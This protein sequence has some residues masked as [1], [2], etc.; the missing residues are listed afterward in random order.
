VV[1]ILGISA[2]YHDSAA[3]IVIDGKIIA[4]A[5]EERFTRLK[6]DA[7]F[8]KNAIEYCLNQANIKCTSLDAVVFYEKPFVKFER[9][10]ES[11][12]AYA[13]KSLAFFIDAIPSWLNTKLF[14]PREID[15]FF[16]NQLKCPIYFTSHHE[17]HQASAFYPSPFN[18]SAILCLDGVG[19]WDTTTWGIGNKNEIILKQKIEFPHSIGLLYS[20]F[21]G[22]LGFKVNSGEYKVMGLAPYGQPIYKNLIL[23]NLIDLKNDGSFWLNQDFFGYCKSNRMYNDNFIKLFDKKPRLPEAPLEQK[24]MDIAASIQA[25]TDDIVLKLAK[26]IKTKSMM[27]NICL[28]GGCALNCV[29]NGKLVKAKLFDNIFIQPASGDAGGALGA[30]LRIYY[31]IFNNNRSI[32]YPDSQYGSLLGPNYSNNEI[33]NILKKYNAKYEYFD[34][35]DNVAKI[36]AKYLSE[37]KIIGHFA[38]RMEFGP[39]ALGNRSIL[40]DARNSKMQKKLNIAIKK[41]ESFRPFAPS[42]LEEDAH[43][44][45]DINKTSPYMLL[46]TQITEN[47]KILIENN[48]QGLEKLQQI[49]SDIPAVTHVDYSA[50]LQ[51]VSKNT[52]AR[53]YKIINEFKNLTGYSVIV[54]TSFNVRG[55]P[56]VC[57]PEDAFKCFM[58]TDIDV[59]IIENFVLLK[60][61]QPKLSNYEE[62]EK[63]HIKD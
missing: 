62:W 17:S 37:G 1:N 36:T 42:C 24:D 56:I 8:P 63:T 52:N 3:A 12:L 2:Y 53:Y 16:N 39:R 61:N 44:Y 50:R 13:P 38:G 4:A 45:F 6:H 23:D 41:R 20:T 33:K 26:D 54:N 49:R 22:Y 47:H 9:I 55:E 15:K 60:E 19:E 25:V 57:S 34:N 31:K 58:Y 59:L 11:S 28:A 21:T 29:A 14:I 10:L 35:F 27:K 7:S 51:T 43:L 40:A 32:N 18:E 48:L 5:Q 30:A 46:T